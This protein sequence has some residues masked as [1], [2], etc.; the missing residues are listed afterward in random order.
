MGRGA[1]PTRHVARLRGRARGPRDP[2]HRRAQSRRGSARRRRGP[3]R[4][5]GGL[6]EL[7]GSSTAPD[8]IARVSSRLGQAPSQQRLD[9]E[10]RQATEPCCQTP[11]TFP[12]G[13][14]N[15]ATRRSPSGSGG[16]TTSPPCA[17]TFPTVSPPPPPTPEARP[18]PLP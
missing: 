2:R 13:S 11:T 6:A 15:V 10:R 18:P 7:P 17:P 8:S 14:R 5:V 1:R 4:L 16:L 9:R 12:A 3:A